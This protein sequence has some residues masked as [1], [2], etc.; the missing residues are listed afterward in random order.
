MKSIRKITNLVGASLRLNSKQ[1]PGLIFSFV[2]L[3][4]ILATVMIALISAISSS[5]SINIQVKLQDQDQSPMSQV[6]VAALE[7]SGYIELKED[8]KINLRIPEG[9]GENLGTDAPIYPEISSESRDQE[10]EEGLLSSL[11]EAVGK[12]MRFSTS[13]GETL[14]ESD[15]SPGEILDFTRYL[16]SIGSQS[17]DLFEVEEIKSDQNLGMISQM[18][19]S[20][21]ITY[22]VYIVIMYA[23][24]IATGRKVSRERGVLA[25]TSSTPTQYSSLAWADFFQLSLLAVLSALAYILILRAIH[26]VLPGPLWQYLLLTALTAFFFLGLVSFLS[27]VIKNDK[28]FQSSLSLVMFA[29]V[30][31]GTFSSMAKPGDSPDWMLAMAEYRPDL[32]IIQAARNIRLNNFNLANLKPNLILAGLGLVFTFIAGL[33]GNSR[34]E[35]I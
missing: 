30:M 23:Y 2:L 1:I 11:L 4:L 22:L 33:I 9:F 13:L 18:K 21:A 5:S 32:I 14:S 35:K 7:E 17:L 24:S 34:K 12:E 29:Y 16:E 8:A 6:L 25:R 27:A 3:P 15:L 20:F 19:E 31:I 28:V 10:F 26:D